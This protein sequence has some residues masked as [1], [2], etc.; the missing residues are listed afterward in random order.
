MAF[1]EQEPDRNETVVVNE[2]TEQVNSFNYFGNLISYLKELYIDNILNNCLKIT[3]FIT[4]CL[5]DRKL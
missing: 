1:Q 3:G 5:D 4:I 2:I